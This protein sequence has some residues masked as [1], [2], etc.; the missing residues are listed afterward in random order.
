MSSHVSPL[1]FEMRALARLAL[2]VV[3][4]QVGLM[5]MGFVDNMMVGR[6][7]AEA[8]AA[9]A[10]GHAW[11]S[12]VIFALAG[13]LMALD[14][15]IA[16]AFGAE[17]EHAVGDHLQRGLIVAG[18][19]GV[20]TTA[21]LW[22]SETALRH[23]G[24][25][26]AIVPPTA[27]YVRIV[28]LGNLPFMLIFALRQFLQALDV[29]RPLVVA[30]VLGNVVN[31]L[32]NGMLIHGWLG[33]PALGLTGAA[34][35]TAASR[36]L[37][38]GFLLVLARRHL[39]GHWRGFDAAARDLSGYALFL[40]IGI[41]IALQIGFELWIF[42][43]VTILI[44]RSSALEQAGHSAALNLASLVFMVPLGISM[45]AAA[46]VGQAIGAGDMPR[47]RRAAGTALG[48]GAVIQLAS[49]ALFLSAPRLCARIITDDEAT[50][51]VAVSLLPIAG[52]FQIFDGLQAIAAGILRGAADTRI[53]AFIALIGYWGCGLP[54]GIALSGVESLGIRGYWWG[55]CIGLGAAA[56]LLVAR[57]RFRFRGAIARVDETGI[58]V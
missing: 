27:E 25:E 5:A 8:L 40:R 57:I 2:P 11:S 3:A 45:A 44:G 24:Q 18:A 58:I 36:W 12:M 31:A 28:S 21:L 16:Q 35:A 20:L 43:V 32:L 26:E 9:V 34:W 48:A 33:A 14:P 4:V 55:L 6:V 53:P 54:I 42:S 50:I 10:L 52:F 13:V 29:V 56:A 17:D 23:F 30:I 46:R 47:A 51:A 39:H 41:P 37:L 22:S 38:L 1:R 49:G 15:L 19:V 7:S